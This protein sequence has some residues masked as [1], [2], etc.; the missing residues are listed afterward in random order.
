MFKHTCVKDLR[1]TAGTLNTV[2]HSDLGESD[3]SYCFQHSWLV[4]VS[5]SEWGSVTAALSDG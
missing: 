3:I 1:W 5:Q 4:D 2:D